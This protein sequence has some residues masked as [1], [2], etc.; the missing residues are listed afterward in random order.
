[1]YQVLDKSTI[2]LEIIPYLSVAKRGFKTKSCLIEVVN[3]ILYKLKT[4]CQWHMLP[5]KSLF[6]EVVLSYKTVFGH[7]RKWSKDGSWKQAWIKQLYDK[8]SYLDLS[9][10]SID[11]SHSTA[12]RGGE[13][14]AYQ[15]RKKRKTTNALYFTDRQ[16]LP[17][18]MSSPIAGNHH[19]LYQ[20]KDSLEEMFEVLNKANI[21]LDGL[22][23]NADS[24]FDSK[25]FRETCLKAGIYPNV[26]LNYRNGDNNDEDYVLDEILYKERFAIERTNAWMDSFRSILNRFDYTASSWESF[27]YIAFFVILI[28]K[29][30]KIKKSR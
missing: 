19:D 16:G 4:G 9:S 20:I 6:S 27:N 25:G 23:V 21:P 3:C 1:M 18:A 15:G 26:A 7:F 29:I 11:G 10:T 14:V 24:G 22:F 30:Q 2:N 12:L 17:L 28:R 5:L 13:E 8:K